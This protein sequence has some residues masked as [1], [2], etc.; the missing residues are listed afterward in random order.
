MCDLSSSLLLPG[1][2][3]LAWPQEASF[4]STTTLTDGIMSTRPA[5]DATARQPGSQPRR[6]RVLG[7]PSLRTA[8]AS[9]CNL[10][11]LKEAKYFLKLIAIFVDFA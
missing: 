10:N 11:L 7:P 2:S 6:G 4:S 3:L 8:N 9:E 5:T 1:A